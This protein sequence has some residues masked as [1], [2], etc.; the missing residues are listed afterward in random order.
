MSCAHCCFACTAKGK[1]M[2]RE[3]FHKAI[4]IAKEYGQVITI[5]GGEPT[6][7]PLFK[8]F[9]LHATWE[10][11]GVSESDGMSA[12]GVI[13]NGSNTEIALTLA[14]LA[15][16][17]MISAKVSNDEFHDPIDPRV[18][19]AFEKPKRDWYSHKEDND[20]RGINGRSMFIIPVGC[21]KGWGN[22]PTTKCVCNSLFIT[23]YGKVYPCG[24]KKTSLGHVATGANITY[25][26]FQG[27]CEKNPSYKDEVLNANKD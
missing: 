9:I 25:E 24:C 17:G 2:S 4:A 19:K 16:Q 6:L 20:N 3:D 13:T 18:Y 21:A 10:L 26:H 12:V 7:H 14:K 27:I 11:A 1:D 5:G 23:P 8:E 22:H 15:Q